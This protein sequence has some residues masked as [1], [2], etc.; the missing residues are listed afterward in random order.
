MPWEYACHAVA[1]MDP[2]AG[3]MTEPAACAVA[4]PVAAMLAD[5]DAAAGA[6]PAA[7]VVAACADTD[8]SAGITVPED[9]PAI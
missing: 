9:T 1:A 4:W 3:L 6:T 5:M 8:W 7:A 2:S